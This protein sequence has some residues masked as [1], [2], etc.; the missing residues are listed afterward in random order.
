LIHALLS[1][2]A[3]GQGTPAAKPPDPALLDELVSRT[4]ALSAF[5]A[6]YQA[7]AAGQDEPTSVRILYRAPDHAKIVFGEEAIYRIHGGFLDV[8]STRRGEAPT[9]AR[10]PLEKPIRERFERLATAMRAEFPAA[11]DSWKS[12]GKPG[13][14]FELSLRDA[15]GSAGKSLQFT[16]SYHLR[17]TVLL[18]WLRDLAN[19]PA[20]SSE[21]DRL[22]FAEPAGAANT[23]I[24]LSTA[25]GFVEKVEMGPAGGASSFELAAIDLSPELDDAAFDLPPRP[26]DALDASAS[27]SERLQQVQTQHHRRDALASIARLVADRKLEWDPASRSHLARVLEVIHAD[28]WMLENEVWVGE[29]RRRMD[30]F[31]AWLRERLRDPALADAAPRKQLEEAV[32][33][34]RTSLPVSAAAGLEQRLA[35]LEIGSDVTDDASLR[36]DFAEIERAAVERTLQSALVEP[37]LREFDLKIEQARLGK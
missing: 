17:S 22:V 20:S 5:V 15:P 34:W 3:L 7:R 18:G 16:A 4:N 28:A 30:E 33:A 36:K 11:A 2:L 37:L 1:V 9:A 32:A 23:R 21:G 10:V 12:G 31:S 13:V 6:E 35:E 8:R 26:A 29:M 14:R 19:E 27:F 24:T 25:T